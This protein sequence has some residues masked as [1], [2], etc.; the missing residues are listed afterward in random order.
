V[1]ATRQEKSRTLPGDEL[2]ERPIG[3]FDHAVTIRR[4]RQEVWPWLAQMG[5]GTRA[6]WYSYDVL[7]NRSQPSAECIRA[8]L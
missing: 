3:S 8:D 6:G 4:P 7:D 2:I 5:A 1:R